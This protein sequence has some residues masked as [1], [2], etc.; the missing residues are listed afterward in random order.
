MHATLLMLLGRLQQ[1]ADFLPEATLGTGLEWMV[2]SSVILPALV[3]ILLVYL[4]PQETV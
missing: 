4:G 2:L 3:L 1:G